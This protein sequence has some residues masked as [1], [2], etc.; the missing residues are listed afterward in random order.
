MEQVKMEA[1]SQVLQLIL[2]VLG[3]LITT[4]L[5][6][7]LPQATQNFLAWGKGKAGTVK[8]QYAAGVLQR[9]ID[10]VGQKVLM[11][12]NTLIEDLKEKAKDGKLTKEELL[13][14]LAKV[15]QTVLDD[16]KQYA[17]AQ[18]VW[19]AALD[20][21]LNDE[22]A[23]QKWIGDVL[24]ATVAKLPPSGLQ[25]GGPALPS[26]PPKNEVVAPA[27]PAVP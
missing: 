16:V 26:A 3:A 11:A 1:V 6:P 8:N 15:K 10:L 20:V 21:F 9:L 2:G 18:G 27:A 19:K 13:E 7:K 25:T 5:L 4:Y 22:N 14:C 12:E 17:T 24:E 23:L